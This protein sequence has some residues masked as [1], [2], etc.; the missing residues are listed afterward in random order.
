MSFEGTNP[1]E[2]EGDFTSSVDDLQEFESPPSVDFSQFIGKKVPIERVMRDR[3]KSKYGPGGIILTPGNEIMAPIVRFETSVITTLKNAKGED[4]E[5]R[6]SEIFSLKEKDG[7]LGWGEKSD[8]KK[9]LNKMKAPH[10]KAVVGKVVII[11][12]RPG[13]QEGQEFLGFIKE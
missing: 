3:I 1:K 9:F 13:K 7:K 8:L 4:I 6:A 12:T 10:P 2:D 11:T 5:V